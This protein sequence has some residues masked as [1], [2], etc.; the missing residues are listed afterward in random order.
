MLKQRVV[1]AL[2]LVVGLLSALFLLDA[3]QIA[4]VVAALFLLGAWEWARLAGWQSVL[5]RLLLTALTGVALYIALFDSGLAHGNTDHPGVVRLL[6]LS[7]GWWLLALVLVLIFP[8]GSDWWGRRGTCSA[9]GLLVLVPPAVGLVWLRWQSPGEWLILYVILLVAAADIAAYFVGRALGR[10]KLAPRVSPGKSLEGF[11]G[12]L[13]GSAIVALVASQTFITQLP[14]LPLI[15][16]S[17]LAALASVLGDLAES[18][19]KRHAG[20]KDSG[21]LLP[22]HGGILDRVDSLTAAVP[23]FALGWWLAGGA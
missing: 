11:A 15:L 12:G 19:V 3:T 5:P 16:V 17:M 6:W 21:T 2:V 20:V 23:V 14:V 8:R 18:M 4:W 10:H 9:L 13:A 22:G 1:T 7:V